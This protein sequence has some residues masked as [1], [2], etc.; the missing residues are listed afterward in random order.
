MQDDLD[1]SP[2]FVKGVGPRR[3]LLLKK[4]GVHTVRGLL[5]YV[6]RDYQ[7]RTR[8]RTISDIQVG[9]VVSVM[10][11]VLKWDSRPTRRAGTITEMLVGDDTG[12]VAATWFTKGYKMKPL[13]QV[14]DRV[15]LSGKVSFYGGLQFS[16]PDVE[17]LASEEPDTQDPMSDSTIVP[18]Y[19]TTEGLAQ[20]A[21]RKIA[22][23]AVEGFLGDL[24][25]P[26]PQALMAKRRLLPLHEALAAAHSPET[27]AQAEEA[28]RRLSYD[29]LLVL[30]LAMAI[31]R[32]GIKD[33]SPGRSFRIG[34]NVDAHARRLFPFRLTQSQRRAIDEIVEDM[35]SPKPMNR[36]LQGDVGSGKTVVALYAMLC[37]IAN[38]AQ[39]ALMAPTEILAEQHFATLS[40]LL[41]DADMRIGLFTGGA[42]AKERRDN[43]EALASGE[44]HLAIGTHALIQSDVDYHD[45]GLVVVDEQH[46][47]GVMQRATL[48]RKGVTP[49]VLV[50][51]ATPIPRTLSLT[52]FGDLDVS[53]IDE[54]PPGRQPIETRL[55]P[56]DKHQDAFE[57]VRGE[58]RSGRQAF[59]VYPLVEESDKVDLRAATEAAEA[60]QKQ[61][62]PEFKVGLIHGRLK[63]REKDCI[64]REFRGG[65][66]D[67]LVATTV[68][69]V[70]IDVPNA[71]I[72]VIEHA[73]RYGLAQ[74]HQLRGRIGRGQHR[75]HCLLF[76]DA[77]TEEARERLEVIAGTSDGF[78]I[79]EADLRFRGPGEFFGTRQH[80]L[81]PLQF[82]NI[83]ED[84]DL[85]RMARQDAFEIT[86]SDPD[87][88]HPDHAVLRQNFYRQFEGRLDLINVG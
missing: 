48:R 68:I 77:R 74:L 36:L 9:D 27:R 6:P 44:I 86:G 21:I 33:E 29:E 49:D 52:V 70:G 25:E 83:I 22:T 5:Y 2:Q 38:G 16:R 69:E 87:L 63:A 26:L 53:T 62:F 67:V 55:I 56:P 66:F 39:A 71:T 57:F 17:V 82:A 73:E 14:G 11:E 75:S 76:S 81:P 47:F 15:L 7:D 41:A 40:E 84:F 28:L 50:M 24:P 61:V 34:P 64:M 19:A 37:A 72:M 31:R 43:L 8:V 88:S 65:R 59:V 10:G 30:E 4:L 80:G 23:S 60:I 1:K 46:R 20:F 12:V 79:A 32:R 58:L 51:T 85:L 18:I 54:L 35:R 13:A 42:T 45:L 78:R 3:V